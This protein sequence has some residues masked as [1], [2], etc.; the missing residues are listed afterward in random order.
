[1]HLAPTLH[2]SRHTRGNMPHRTSSR[3]GPASLLATGEVAP[4]RDGPIEAPAIPG[5]N[6]MSHTRTPRQDH[7]MKDRGYCRSMKVR[8]LRQ[9]WQAGHSNVDR[10]PR[11]ILTIGVAHRRHGLPS[12]P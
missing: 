12:R 9:V 2:V 4:G 11:A 7:R 3:P 8:V 5:Q 10:F 6:L 1:M